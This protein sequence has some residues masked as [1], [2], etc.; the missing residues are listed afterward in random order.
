[1]T[2]NVPEDAEYFISVKDSNGLDLSDKFL[3][4]VSEPI[5]QLELSNTSNERINNEI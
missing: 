5:N 2:E 4:K 1:M 3:K